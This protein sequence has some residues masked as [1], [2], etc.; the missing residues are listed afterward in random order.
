MMMIKMVSLC[1][2]NKRLSDVNKRLSDDDELVRTV[3]IM[4]LSFALLRPHLIMY[5]W[6]CYA[7]AT[8]YSEIMISSSKLLLN[9]RI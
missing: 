5:H 9:A 6:F 2:G 7:N 4:I 1:S 3:G 8:C